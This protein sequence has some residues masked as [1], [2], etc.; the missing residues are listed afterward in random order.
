[1]NA[2]DRALLVA[3]RELAAERRHPDGLVAALTFTGLLVLMES[4]AFGPGQAR[5]PVVASALFWIAILFAATLVATR[6]FDRELEDDAIDAVLALGGGREALY[7]G[8]LLAISVVLAIVALVAAVLSGLLLGLDVALAGH[9]A[10]VGVLGILA[11][12]PVIVLATL[13]ALRVRARVALVPILSFPILMPQ[14]I[15]CTQGAAAALSGDG[16][17]AL[18]WA[19]ILAAF[20]LVYGV[21]GLTIVPAAIE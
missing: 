18:G 1:L 7:A 21:L 17:A 5:Q 11:L 10:L 15:A 8:K 19:G 14:L 13:L 20:A 6:S 16:A 3:A 4:L 9:L 12:P 2:L